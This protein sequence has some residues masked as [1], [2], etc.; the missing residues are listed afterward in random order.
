MIVNIGKRIRVDAG[1]YQFECDCATPG[2]VNVTSDRG[3][4]TLPG[5]ADDA[6]RFIAAYRRAVTEPIEYVE[7]ESE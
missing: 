4:I 5:N 3:S 6:E 7:S 2:A 1:R